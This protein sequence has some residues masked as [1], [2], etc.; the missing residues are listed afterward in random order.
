MA[1]D[2]L[3]TINVD[4]SI[5]GGSGWTNVWQKMY[6]L[7]SPNQYVLDLSGVAA[8]QNNFMFRFRFD[9]GS[10][11][12]G[13]YWQIDDI[14]FEVFGTAASNPPGRASNPD[15][16]EGEVDVSIDAN[17]SWS[18]GSDTTSHNVYFDGVFQGNQPGTGFDPGTLDYSMPYTWRIDEVN[19]EGKTI[20]SDWSFT[21][22][23]APVLPGQASNPGPGDAAVDV[24]IDA[25]LSWTAGSDTTSHDVYFNGMSQG[26]QPGTGFDPGTLAYSTP[27]TWQ[28][29]EENA[30]GTTTGVLWRFTTQAP[31]TTLP[32]F[33]IDD[34]NVVTV[35]ANGKRNRGEA[36]VTV[37]NEVDAVV[38]WCCSLWYIQR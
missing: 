10:Y 33:H 1:F 34:I 21:T 20:G 5:D 16:V 2:L 18:A 23:A 36:T 24:S 12:Q 35:A 29:D 37:H 38:K 15:P 7:A 25:D 4:V 26:N 9:S 3:E 30:A 27:Y 19:D 28:I 32:K 13:N 22:E 11:S 31:P 6:L 14:E 17:L 8:G